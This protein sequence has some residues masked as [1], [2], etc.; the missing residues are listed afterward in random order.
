MATRTR[1]PRKIAAAPEA[2]RVAPA[3]VRYSARK[4]DPAERNFRTY[5]EALFDRPGHAAAV[6]AHNSLV[7]R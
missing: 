5:F 4:I 6:A 7:Q 2:V 3:P 1:K